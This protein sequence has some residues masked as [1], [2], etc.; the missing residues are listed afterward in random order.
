MV[1]RVVDHIAIRHG[2]LEYGKG[3]VVCPI[4]VMDNKLIG[5]VRRVGREA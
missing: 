5:D 3:L 4:Q 2:L 1:N